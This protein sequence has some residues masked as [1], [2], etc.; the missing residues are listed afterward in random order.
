MFRMCVNGYE[1]VAVMIMTNRYFTI[2]NILLITIAVY[3]SISAFYK[4]TTHQLNPVPPQKITGTRQI[5]SLED[6]ALHPLSY[7]QTIV[8]RNLFNTLKD[9]TSQP[10]P[11]KI[12]TLKQTAL[13]LKLWGTVTGLAGQPYAVIEEAKGRQQNL[14]RVGDTVQNATVK[15][16]LREKVILSV[17]GQDEI[18]EIEHVRSLARGRQPHKTV[19]KSRGQKITLKRSQIESSVKNVNELLKQVKIRP[20][21]ENGQAAGLML[22]SIKRGSIFR[23][24]GLRSGDVI[25]GVNGSSLVSVDD[26]LKIY[27]SMK[28]SSSMSIDIKRRGRNRTIDYNIE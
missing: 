4:I 11:I 12:E 25:T 21:T 23:R 22:S 28:S 13:N 27:E 20:H 8:E 15:M 16:I 26:A 19:R 17:N 2:S 1:I 7:Y 14:Y 10:I 5:S 9:G 6:E 24:M 3:F 18:L